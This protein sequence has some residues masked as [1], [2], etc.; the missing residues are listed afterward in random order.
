MFDA[1]GEAFD[2]RIVH[3]G[4]D[5]GLGEGILEILVAVLGARPMAML[6]AGV[7]GA[8]SKAAVRA[9]VFGISEAMDVAG[10]GGNDGPRDVADAGNGNKELKR[11]SGT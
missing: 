10:F 11:N 3:H 4:L 1:S 8:R 9:K 6:S 2:V 5:G 7:L